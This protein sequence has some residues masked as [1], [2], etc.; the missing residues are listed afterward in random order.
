MKGF[1]SVCEFVEANKRVEE[2][3]AGRQDSK[4]SFMTPFNNN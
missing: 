3:T 1:C 2:Q 4:Q